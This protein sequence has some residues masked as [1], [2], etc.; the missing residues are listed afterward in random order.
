MR[1]HIFILG[2]SLTLAFAADT[3]R[4]QSLAF[5]FDGS[6][7]EQVRMEARAAVPPQPVTE[8][9]EVP[10]PSVWPLQDTLDWYWHVPNDGLSQGEADAGVS[11]IRSGYFR[12]Y[13]T[14]ESGPLVG[15]SAN[16]K[17]IKIKFDVSGTLHTTG[18][19]IGLFRWV[20]MYRDMSQPPEQE[21][22]AEIITSFEGKNFKYTINLGSEA[23]AR[24]FIDAVYSCAKLA[25]VKLEDTVKTGF[26]VFDLTAA[27]AQALGKTRI[28]NALVISVAAGGPGG[29]A[30]IA[31][32][33]VI[34]EV[35]GE[36]LRS[37]AHFY[38]MIRQ[39]APG[40]IVKFGC[41]TR[42][43][44]ITESGSKS[45]IWKP[46]TVEMQLN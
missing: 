12:N 44:V 9:T 34:S 13:S 31:F 37:A 3:A 28:D 14:G 32:M 43:E 30:G 36:P 21:W 2:S 33:D 10:V 4:A 22:L 11:R 39:L 35:N 8:I 17:M 7:A 41:L 25:K 24:A 38:S 29:K 40:S 42:T 26:F 5:S 45:F 15:V 1:K 46:K 16:K 20:R 18:F 23:E 6:G 27:Q 19:P